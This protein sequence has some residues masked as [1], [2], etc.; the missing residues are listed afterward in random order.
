M[1]SKVKALVENLDSTAGRRFELTIQVLVIVSLLEY[2]ISTL[3][4]LPE[5]MKTG[6]EAIEVVVVVVFTAEYLLRLYAADNRLKF[7][8][9]FYGVVDLVAVLPFYA[10][11]GVDLRS[12]RSIRLLRVF[13]LLKFARYTRA[14]DHLRRA[15][16]SVKEEI[17]IYFV[18]TLIV[19]FLA[20]VGIHF[21][22]SEAQPEAFGSI[23]HCAWWA[24]VTLTTVGYGDAYPVT[25]G[26]RLFTS[27]L[28]IA[29]LGLVAVP[30]GIVASALVAVPRTSDREDR[31]VVESHQRGDV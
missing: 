20:S 27:V 21:F 16:L 4:N 14:V 24:V 15:F 19:I 26:G 17:A 10:G 7:A 6:L 29:G 11:L 30:S 9:S 18:A 31:P 23:F 3:R 12:L 2:S 22:E 1:R 13:R 5:P 28:L 8:T 25:V